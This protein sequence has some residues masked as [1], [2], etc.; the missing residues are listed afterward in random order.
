MCPGCCPNLPPSSASVLLPSFSPP[1]PFC[2]AC[3][4]RFFQ[5]C[6]LACAPL[7]PTARQA[8]LFPCQQPHCSLCSLASF[9]SICCRLPLSA[10]SLTLPTQRQPSASHPLLP[11]L[12]PAPCKPV[13]PAVPIDTCLSAAD[14]LP[15]RCNNRQFFVASQTEQQRGTAKQAWV[16]PARQVPNSLSQAAAAPAS[17]LSPAARL[18]LLPLALP[19][20]RPLPGRQLPPLLLLPL[21]LRP[22]QLSL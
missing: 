4:S 9:A 12:T 21:P 5:P 14:Q 17:P 8:R 1:P 6:P 3:F 2:S 13:P 18:P 11:L 22:L 19:L 16:E 10:S 15:L 20:P 7:P